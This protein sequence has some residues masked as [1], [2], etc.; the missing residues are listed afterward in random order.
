MVCT[1]PVAG[2]AVALLKPGAAMNRSGP[3]VQRFLSR[4]G[5]EPE[6]CMLVHDDMDLALGDVRIKRDGGD[7]G[8]KGVRSVISA[9]GTGTLPR[10]RIGVRR[11][12]DARQAERLVLAAF[13]GEDETVLAPALEKAVRMVREHVATVRAREQ[14]GVARP[15]QA[16]P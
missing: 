16:R 8:H 12:G 10:V 2:N 11:Q 15:A 9:L 7:A 4:G 1:I 6:R 14:A 13:S 5:I 3:A